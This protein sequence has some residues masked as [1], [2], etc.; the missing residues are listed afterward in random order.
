MR[1]YQR[2]S[3]DLRDMIRRD[4]GNLLY[5]PRNAGLL[6]DRGDPAPLDPAGHDSLE[7]REI[8][9]HVEREPVHGDPASDL[10]SD[11]ADLVSSHPD[12][13]VVLVPARL[14]AEIGRRTDEHFLELSE[15]G[16]HVVPLAELEYRVAHELSRAVIRGPAPAIDL[17]ERDAAGHPL[18]FVEDEVA[19]EGSLSERVR[20]WVFE[21]HE[22]VP[23]V[24]VEPRQEQLSLPRP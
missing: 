20:R 23:D 13:G 7:H 9:R 1:P 6:F 18:A 16:D 4:G 5:G 24:A 21:E 14:D 11:G 15:I 2:A 12:S 19:L 10:Y 22:R 3:E 17:V 8:G